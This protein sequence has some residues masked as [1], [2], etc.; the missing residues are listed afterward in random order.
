MPQELLAGEGDDFRIPQVWL[1]INSVLGDLHLHFSPN[2]IPPRLGRILMTGGKDHRD[3]G[4]GRQLC[5]GKN[6]PGNVT[7]TD[8]RAAAPPCTL[9]M[10]PSCPEHSVVPAWRSSPVHASSISLP[11]LGRFVF[12]LCGT[13]TRDRLA[14]TQLNLVPRTGDEEKKRTRKKRDLILKKGSYK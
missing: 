7:F 11:P 13:T 10:P 6:E 12:S 9:P 2:E 5:S 3:R 1:C 8:A 14:L 4:V